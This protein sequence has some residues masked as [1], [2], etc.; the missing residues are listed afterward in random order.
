M[1][2]SYVLDA[3]RVDNHKLDS[4]ALRELKHDTIKF[5]EICGKGKNKILFNELSPQEALNYAAEDADVTLSVYNRILPRI[6][7]DKKLTVYKRIENPLIDVLI[8][9]EDTGVIINPVKLK[10]ISNNLSKNIVTLE[11]EIFK[12]S[13]KTFNIGSP[14]QLGEVLFDELKIRG[15]KKYKK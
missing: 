8:E 7:N 13:K 4:L 2:I 6:I 5:E 9:M 3:G 14:K 12:L 10:E 15:G 11:E 1:C